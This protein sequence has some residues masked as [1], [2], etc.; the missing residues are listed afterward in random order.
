MTIGKKLFLSFGAAVAL[1]LILGG[2]TMFSIGNLGAS[3]EKVVNVYAKKRF[4]ASQIDQNVTAMISAERGVIVRSYMKDPAGSAANYQ[5]FR[6]ASDLWKKNM[7]EFIPLIETAEGRKVTDDMQASRESAVRFH[8]DFYRLITEGKIDEASALEKD[9][10]IPELVASSKQAGQLIQL[11][12]ELL[13]NAL[14]TAEGQVALARWVTI[15][16]IL[17]SFVVGMI[18]ILVVRKI[19]ASLRQ[20]VAELSEGA[21]QVSSAAGEVSSSSQSLAQGSSEQA[22][23]LEE[24]SA[25]SEEINSMAR[26]NSENSRVA[27]DLM[28]Q[29]QVKFVETNHALNQSVVAMGEI[30]TQ[31]DKIAKIIKVIDE[32]AFQ[33]NILALNAAVEAARAG[34]AGMGFAVVADEVRNLAQRCAQAAKDT[35]ALIEDSIAKS[36]DGKVKVDQVA[37][38]IRSITEDANKVKTL[39]DEVN[40]GSEE[41]ARGIDQIGKAITQMEQVTQK[42]AANAEQSAAAAEQLN[43]QSETLKDVVERLTGMVGA[44]DE[45]HGQSRSSRR[46]GGG[47][48]GKARTSR[49]PTETAP[50]LTSLR[51]AVSR[52]EQ[53]PENAAPALAGHRQRG[54][55]FPLDDQ[56]K[57]F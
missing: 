10:I 15:S 54:E 55:S 40:L 45:G 36:N 39:V 31:S 23:S 46:T 35:S 1:T 20:V 47:G 19:N 50:G 21:E 3:I 7:E 24:T 56:F 48:N 6:N 2:V 17:L 12:V 13:Q 8:E 42:T 22:A 34:E 43:A 9:K 37:T 4:L 26:K 29:S 38:A 32:I 25:S 51:K 57:E 49:R 5:D 14:K 18:V 16:M 52:R 44:D 41:Q 30:N 28:G 33:T 11:Q 27:A 53:T